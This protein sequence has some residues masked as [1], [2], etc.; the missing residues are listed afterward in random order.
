L[1]GAGID[2]QIGGNT[3]GVTS[4][5]S[6]GTM[7]MAGGSN[8]T[9]S[10]NGNGIT[11]IGGGGTGGI[12]LSIGGNTSGTLALISTG[13]ALFAGGNN[14]TLSQNGNS[15]SIIGAAGG[16]GG[17]S[18]G[19]IYNGGN[20]TGQSS[21]SS[22]ALSSL[23]FSGAGLISL[24][25]S[26]NSL[27]ISAPQTTG[28]SQ[29]I[30]ATGNTTQSSSGTASIG[31]LLFQGT[32]GVS[33]GYS[34]GS[35]VISG[36][37]GGGGG[38]TAS[39]YAT[40]NTTQNS[41][42][43]LA[44]SSLL[45]NALGA[46]TVG[47]SNGSI[48]LSAPA[49]SSL[50]ATGQVSIS[51]NAST[52]SIGVPT[53]SIYATGNTT[54]GTSGTVTNGSL[55]FQGAGN[56]SVGYS[57]GSV[58]VSGATAAGA[59]TAGLYALGNT[60]QNSSTTLA[61]SGLSFNGLGGVSVGYSNGSIQISGGAGGGASTAGLYATGNTTQN[62]STTLALSS[63]LF[64]GTG[65]VSVGYSNGSVVI[66]GG[67]AGGVST[68]GLYALGNT[69]QNSST[70]LNLSALSF[71]GLG[72]ATMGYSGGSIQVSVPTQTNQSGGLYGLGN[73]TLTSST[74]YDA[75]SLSFNGLGAMTVGYSAG[76]GVMLS[77]PA[78]SSLSAT[79]GL[80]LSINGSTISIGNAVVSR[81]IY[82]VDQL[83]PLS[84]P[85]NGSL[86]IQ[87]YPC[88]VALTATRLDAL[89]GWSN[90]S[91][92]TTAT[93]AIAMSAWAIVYTK[94][95]S[96]LS[97][98][99]S[100]ST[101]TTYSYASNTAGNTQ[102][103]SPAIRPVSV[104]INLN[105]TQGEYYV[106]FNFSTTVSS[107]G[108]STTSLGQTLSMYGGSQLQSASNF[109]EFTN[110]TATSTNLYGGMGIYTAA[111]A[112]APVSIGLANIAQTGTALSAANIGLVFRNV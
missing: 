86:S 47:F 72:A 41:S 100:G 79:G 31:S 73:T 7:T 16:T 106:G 4:L 65:G 80:S 28:L 6:T 58:V 94:N 46:Q 109:A 112:G 38:G 81:S 110:A 62:S 63:L 15:V 33:V 71:N 32:G 69:T 82:P 20:T 96:T 17:A 21:S 24:G 50:S 76:S 66:S 57:N 53:Q 99:S 9:L 13:T 95:A 8:I 51:V 103:T 48:Q 93:M 29:S 107:V 18:T 23:N 35:V 61:L 78:T 104:P 91:A 70:T 3:L 75:R 67:A 59:T 77:A 89:V 34:N 101:Q 60:T 39:I 108:L 30:Y 14:I 85:G 98:L 45:F 40:G 84:A 90:A 68:A 37:T 12:D 83:Q 102:L 44:V 49:T 92:A 26:S 1:A 19:N 74:T 111:T 5:I 10:Q 27:I 88:D 64:Q 43:S 56:V 105:F 55:L 42:T 2:A 97:S 54:Q 22:Y 87:Y 52:I 25:W 36:A 11:F